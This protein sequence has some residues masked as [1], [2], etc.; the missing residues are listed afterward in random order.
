MI[1]REVEDKI[2]ELIVNNGGFNLG[3]LKLT[4]DPELKVIVNNEV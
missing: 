1:R 4:A 2:S 3:R